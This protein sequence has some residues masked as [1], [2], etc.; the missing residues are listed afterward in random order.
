MGII[1][2][3]YYYYPIALSEFYEKHLLSNLSE[4]VE[5]VTLKTF[6]YNNHKENHTSHHSVLEQ[7]SSME[8]NAFMEPTSASISMARTVRSTIEVRRRYLFLSFILKKINIVLE[9][10]IITYLIYILKKNTPI[11]CLFD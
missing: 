6:N 5:Y 7:N 11:N 2:T 10:L 1:I 9:D 4:F 3:I 8:Q